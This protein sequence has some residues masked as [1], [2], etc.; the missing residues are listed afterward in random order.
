MTCE[1]VSPLGERAP[2]CA[3]APSV[4]SFFG[5][6]KTGNDTFFIKIRT[7][8]RKKKHKI[9]NPPPYIYTLDIIHKIFLEMHIECLQAIY[10]IFKRKI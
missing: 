9:N 8:Q 3:A 1:G 5:S 2:F 10:F 6:A 7:C 4:F